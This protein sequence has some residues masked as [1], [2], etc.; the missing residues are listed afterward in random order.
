MTYTP[1][2]NRDLLQTVSTRRTVFSLNLDYRIKVRLQLGVLLGQYFKRVR[3]AD[4][5]YG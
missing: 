4:D 3:P 5:E 2:N 1:K